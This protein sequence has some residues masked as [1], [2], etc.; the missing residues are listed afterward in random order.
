MTNITG[1]PAST[2]PS[3]APG[4]RLAAA[5]RG[6]RDHSRR[7]REYSRWLRADAVAIRTLTAAGLKRSRAG[8]R[9]A[10]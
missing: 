1:H 8:D 4:Y 3:R 6:L 10:R 2:V 5:S 9:N 7:L